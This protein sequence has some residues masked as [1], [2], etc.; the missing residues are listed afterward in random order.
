[1]DFSIY[2]LW[3]GEQ[4]L[5]E[6]SFWIGNEVTYTP[7]E[8]TIMGEVFYPYLWTARVS[9]VEYCA[10]ES[11]EDG[12]TV[13]VVNGT[14]TPPT[15]LRASFL[16]YYFWLLVICPQYWLSRNMEDMANLFLFWET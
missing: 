1:M 9:T 5:L 14:T 11:S 7:R 3:E 13:I 2:R 6:P 15:K 4:S 16:K 8:V 10:L 12:E